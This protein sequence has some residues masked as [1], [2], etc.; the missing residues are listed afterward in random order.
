[1]KMLALYFGLC[2]LFLFGYWIYHLFKDG[3]G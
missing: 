2:A 1:M 3:D